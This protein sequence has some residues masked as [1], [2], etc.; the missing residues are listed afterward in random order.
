MLLN[1]FNFEPNQAPKTHWMTKR[2]YLPNVRSKS[3]QSLVNK[4]DLWRKIKKAGGVFH[5][6]SHPHHEVRLIPA[7]LICVFGPIGALLIQMNRPFVSCIF[8]FYLRPSPFTFR[9]IHLA[10][11]FIHVEEMEQNPSHRAE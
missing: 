2:S 8:G 7:A 11:V 5:I 3:T 4:C 10:S 9:F 1:S 6:S